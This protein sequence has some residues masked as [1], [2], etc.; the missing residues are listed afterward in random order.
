MAVG[1][2]VRTG[3]GEFA[4]VTITDTK[5]HHAGYERRYD[6][7]SSALSRFDVALPEHLAG[8]LTHLDP[9]FEHLT[10]GDQGRRA[11]RIREHL[12]P[13]DPLVF[14]AAFRPVDAPCR[15]LQYL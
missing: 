11:R 13:G 15:P 6:E 10:Y 9:D 8:R 4:Y 5:P 1:T 7:Y 14:F 12:R 3:T 2:P